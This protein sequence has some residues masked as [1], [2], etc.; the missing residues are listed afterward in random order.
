MRTKIKEFDDTEYIKTVRGSG[1]IFE[2]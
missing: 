1:Y 2:E